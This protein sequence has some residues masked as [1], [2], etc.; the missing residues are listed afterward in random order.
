MR[1]RKPFWPPRPPSPGPQR[2]RPCRRRCPVTLRSDQVEYDVMARY[3]DSRAE[4][5]IHFASGQPVHQGQI[6]DVWHELD[7]IMTLRMATRTAHLWRH[8]RTC[9]VSSPTRRVLRASDIVHTAWKSHSRSTSSSSIP[10]HRPSTSAAW[11]SSS[12]QYCSIVRIVSGH[13]HPIE[14]E[15]GKGRNSP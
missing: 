4:C 8:L 7:S 5:Q 10:W 12:E 6:G 11:M 3:E 1:R 14:A 15:A 9:T 13:Q 2:P